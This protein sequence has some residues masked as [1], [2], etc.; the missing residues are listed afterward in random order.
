MVFVTN[1]GRFITIAGIGAKSEADGHTMYPGDMLDQCRYAFMKIKKALDA[2]DAT[3]A[4]VTRMVTFVTDMG[5]GTRESAKPYQDYIT[6]KNEAFGTGPVP[7]GT[8]VQITRLAAPEMLIEINFDAV[9]A[10]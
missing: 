5:G 1:P 2:Q 4:D 8:L 10:N 7:A 9:L 3:L 6:C